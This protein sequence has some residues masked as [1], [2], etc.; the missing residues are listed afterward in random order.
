[1]PVNYTRTKTNYTVDLLQAEINGDPLIVP[2]CLGITGSGDQL[3]CEF[4][5]ALSLGEETQLDVVIL[6]HVI[7]EDA[8]E[9]N[10][11]P[12]SDLDDFKLA[13][14][15]SNK[16]H[17]TDG[18]AYAMWIGCGDDLTEPNDRPNT[19]DILDID[20]TTG[21]LTNSIDIRFNPIH[22]K[23]WLHEAYLRFENGG[24]GD[25]IEGHILAN[26]TDLQQV[27][28]LDLDVDVDG[29]ITYVGPG[30]G[31]HGFA[32]VDIQLLPRTFSKDGDWNYDTENGLV[33]APNG[34]GVYKINQNEMVVHQYYSKISCR[35]TCPNYFSMTSEDTAILPNGYFVRIT[36]HNVSNTTWCA[37]VIMEIYRE[38]TYNP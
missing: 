21:T 24:K 2:S 9:V 25:Y 27:A 16:P 13:V 37:N 36:C 15:S 5:V 14:H 20:L 22:G 33:P 26:P 31:S 18:T 1:M 11:L 6:A 17:I 30:I 12:V 4:V 28:N 38:R 32:N 10:T 3:I 34:D 7:E 29:W 35:G 8:I 19:G 23:V